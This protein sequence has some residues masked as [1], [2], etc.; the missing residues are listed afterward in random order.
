MTSRDREVRATR[1]GVAPLVVVAGVLLTVSGRAEQLHYDAQVAWI[2]AGTVDLSLERDG[3]RYELSGMVATSG[4]MNRFFRWQGRFAATGRFV[5]GYPVTDAYLLLEDDGETREVLLAFKDKTTIHATDRESEE[6]ERPPG[7]DLMSATFLAPH[8]LA[9][10]T[11][12]HDGEDTYR[13]DLLSSSSSRLQGSTQSYAGTA[14]R[15]AYRFYEDGRRARRIT[16]WT[17]EVD[18][19][20]V[21]VRIRI[22]VPVFPDGLLRLRLDQ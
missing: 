5:D 18:G 22:R 20:E 3:D 17:A 4:A 16:V 9:D 8:C 15:C 19:R 2:R 21:P 1:T 12:V 14:R 13:V 11:I 10:G 6:V 7:S